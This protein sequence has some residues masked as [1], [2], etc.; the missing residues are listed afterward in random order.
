MFALVRGRVHEYPQAHPNK[1]KRTDHDKGHFPT[2]GFCQQRNRNRSDQSADRSAGIENRSCIG[3]VFLRE[4]FCRNL[5]GCGKVTCFTQRQNTTG[6]QEEIHTHGCQYHNNISCC[7]NQLRC[8]VHTDIMFGCNT[9]TGMETGSERPNT[10]SPKIS[11]LRA[12]PVDKTTGKQHTDC[13]YN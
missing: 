3:T 11:F 8:T 13:I 2:P 12:H 5:D 10:D 1:T 7:R 9:A 6:G 4:V